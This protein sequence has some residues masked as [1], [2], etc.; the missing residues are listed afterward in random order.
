MSARSCAVA[1]V[2][3]LLVGCATFSNDGG[4]D[5]VAS[6]TRERVGQAPRWQR[7]S[8]SAAAVQQRVDELLKGP[9]SADGAVEIA[10]LN[11]AALQATFHELGIAEADLVRAGRLRNPTFSFKNVSGGGVGE[12]ERAI[13]F[14]IL[15]IL[16]LPLAQET[17]QARFGQAQMRIASDAVSTAFEARRAFYAAVASQELV[18]YYQQVKEAADA[19]SDLARRMRE[20]GNFSKLA[21]MNEQAFYADATAQLARARHQAVADRERLNRALGLSGARIAYVLPDRLPE[22]PR[23]PIE[24]RDAEQVALD[25]RLDVLQAKASTGAMAK[26]LQL[27]RTTGF[28]NVLHAGYANKSS[29]GEPLEN[30]YEIELEIPIFDFGTTR[31]ARAEALYMQSVQR[32]ADVAVRATSEVREAYSAYRTA[33]D[34]AQH[35]RDEIIPLRRR[36]SEENLLL[37]NGMLIS[38]FDLLADARRQV[39]AVTAS[40]EAQRDFWLASAT[41]EV[42][43]T[44]TS[45]G[46]VGSLTVREAAASPIGEGH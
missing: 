6:L 4:F 8:D 21:Q 28:I 39:M 25:K 18:K 17:E 5:S 16:T 33:Y 23:Q 44:G 19:S 42:A 29:T 34:L 27:T 46:Q 11:N 1:S 7:D 30:G 13:V 9:L 40:V 37:Y 14:D 2:A 12:I 10:L 38:V 32:T 24:P 20:A 26:A 31:V 15:S 43:L 45:P 35:Y 22:L 3:V 36:I 41:L